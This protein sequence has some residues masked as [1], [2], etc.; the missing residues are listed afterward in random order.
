MAFASQ[1]YDPTG[2]GSK[3]APRLHTYTT[4]DALTTVDDSGYFDSMASVIKSGD[5]LWAYSTNS[6]TGRLYRFTNT[7]NVIT[8]TGLFN[9]A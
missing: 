9:A 1:G 5:L 7:S 8:T 2:S 4:A 3:G 6:S